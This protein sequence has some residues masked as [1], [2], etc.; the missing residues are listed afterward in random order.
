MVW[1]CIILHRTAQGISS[2]TELFEAH[3]AR[4][5]SALFGYPHQA[6]LSTGVLVPRYQSLHL[7]RHLTI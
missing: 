5:P 6:R 3:V 7:G 2:N 4:D 1:T